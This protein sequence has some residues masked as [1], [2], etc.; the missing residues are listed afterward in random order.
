MQFMSTK[1]NLIQICYLI[2][3]MW[4]SR[5]HLASLTQHRLILI[6]FINLTGT[7]ECKGNQLNYNTPVL[8]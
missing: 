8:C 6:Q 4:S 5:P 1:M 7:P 2:S 3:K